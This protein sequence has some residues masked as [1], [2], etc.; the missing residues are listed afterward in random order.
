MNSYLAGTSFGAA[1]ACTPLNGYANNDP[2][3]PVYLRESQIKNPTGTWLVLDEDQE[4]INDAMMLVDV[5]GGRRFLDLPSR[6]HGN[7]YGINFTDG[8]AEIYVFRDPASINWHVGDMGGL[9]D[10]QKLTN[11]TTH[12]F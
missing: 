9:N 3:H 6:A 4:S 2:L 12:P 7:G 10:W 11:V 1:G 8:H 5:G